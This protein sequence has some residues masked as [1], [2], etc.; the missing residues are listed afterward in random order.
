MLLARIFGGRG[1][2][3]R[4]RL[5]GEGNQLGGG[6]REGERGEAVSGGPGYSGRQTSS[7]VHTNKP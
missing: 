7:K 6:G 1:C 4:G 2:G 3:G 5:V